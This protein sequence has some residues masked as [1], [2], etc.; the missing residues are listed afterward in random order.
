MRARDR[1]AASGSAAR[2]ADQVEAVDSG[3]S[4]VRS[5]WLP[6]SAPLR[7]SA[8]AL[9]KNSTSSSLPAFWASAM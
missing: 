8:C 9:R 2:R 6:I 4:N 1:R 3:P 5:I 7:L